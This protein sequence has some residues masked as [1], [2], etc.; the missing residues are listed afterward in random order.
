L[1]RK[2]GARNKNYS[3]TSTDIIKDACEKNVPF[4]TLKSKG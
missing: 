4:L 1:S 2:K 3:K